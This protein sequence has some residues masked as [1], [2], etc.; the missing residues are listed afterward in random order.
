[1]TFN[2]P[3]K[4]S[5]KHRKGTKKFSG[6]VTS[7]FDECESGRRVSLFHIVPGFGT[8]R[9]VG[10]TTTNASGGWNIS[11]KNPRGKYYASVKGSRLTTST[12][13]T[14]NC[15]KARSRRVRG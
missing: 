10:K 9:R 2:S 4:I 1:M 13:D 14:I 5:I 15:R 6:R 12:G 11:E 8:A 3:S 7:D